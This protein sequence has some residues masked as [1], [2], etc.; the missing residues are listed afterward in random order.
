M[1]IR[2]RLITRVSAVTI[3]LPCF[4]SIVQFLLKT[5]HSSLSV[6]PLQTDDD[7][8]DDDVASRLSASPELLSVTRVSP[9]PESPP[10]Q[11]PP[12]AGSGSPPVGITSVLKRC[13][14]PGL[15]CVVCG[16]MSSGKHYGILACNGCSGFFKRS[17]RRRLIYRYARHINNNYSIHTYILGVS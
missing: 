15:T 13:H 17:V 6:E 5:N 9:A 11:P 10:L 4:V 12:H 3:S 14:S 8:S 7:N 2:K 1:A 16:D